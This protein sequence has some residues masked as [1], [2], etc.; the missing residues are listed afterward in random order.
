VKRVGRIIHYT[1]SGR[2]VIEAEEKILPQTP[3]YNSSGHRLA[4][5]IDL[6]GPVNNPFIIAKPVIG[7]AE[8]MVNAV[9][10]VKME[11]RRKRKG[12]G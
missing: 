7:S 2:Y 1:K 11:K 4:V 6:I 8:K 9:V 12:S 5:T 10:Y 3:L